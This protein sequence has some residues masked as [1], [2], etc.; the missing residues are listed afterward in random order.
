MEST[1]PIAHCTLPR[2]KGTVCW[3]GQGPDTQ[4]GIVNTKVARRA[5]AGQTLPHQYGPVMDLICA[6]LRG[7]GGGVVNC[8]MSQKNTIGHSG[9]TAFLKIL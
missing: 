9:I 7:W 1:L 5:R 6:P 3:G 8:D 4:V 2:T